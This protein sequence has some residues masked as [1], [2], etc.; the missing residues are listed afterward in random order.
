MAKPRQAETDRCEGAVWRRSSFCQGA[1]QTCVDVAFT[2]A[3][4]LVRDSKDPSG[5]R[6]AFSG[7]EWRVFLLGVYAGEFDLPSG[8][9]R[10]AAVL[11]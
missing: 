3:E 6:L 9:T 11:S 7:E 5:A 10:S 1:D 2:R 4:V 8:M